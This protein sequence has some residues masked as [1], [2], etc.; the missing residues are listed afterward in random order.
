MQ[1]FNKYK[2]GNERQILDPQMP[3]VLEDL[4][5]KKILALAFKCAAPTRKD[6]P[7]MQEVV[8][9]LWGIRKDYNSRRS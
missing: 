6:R 8:E 5:V 1:A 2:E 9:Q 7:A 4:V 3:E